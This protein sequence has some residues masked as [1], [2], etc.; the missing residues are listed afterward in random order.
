MSV[1]ELPKGKKPQQVTKML[2]T[3]DSI[4]E[5]EYIDS[6]LFDT[7]KVDKQYLARVDVWI[8]QI[9]DTSAHYNLLNNG[10]SHYAT[11]K[12]KSP[13]EFVAD[14]DDKIKCFPKALDNLSKETITP[15]ADSLITH[16]VKLKMGNFPLVMQTVKYDTTKK[17]YNGDG[18]V[19]W[20]P[21]G[22]DVRLKVKFDSV[23][24]N[25]NYEIIKGTAVSTAM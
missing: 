3:K 19:I 9:G 14:I 5:A 2:Y 18:Y 13:P 17:V 20:H 21:L 25:K 22:V 23:Q 24:I 16:Q 15:S 4:T 8:K 12:L 1:A 10:H 7:L 6:L 11:F